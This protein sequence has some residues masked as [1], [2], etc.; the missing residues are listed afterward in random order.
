[1]PASTPRESQVGRRTDGCFFHLPR[2]TWVGCRGN[3][4]VGGV[5][6]RQL[7]W[8]PAR[9]LVFPLN[10]KLH[11]AGP[12][13]QSVAEKG[14]RG[15]RLGRLPTRSAVSGSPSLRCR[16]GLSRRVKQRAA[17]MGVASITGHSRHFCHGP[18]RV[19]P[20]APIHARRP[21]I[22]RPQQMDPARVK[23]MLPLHAVNLDVP[24]T[25]GRR[26]RLSRPPPCR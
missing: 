10:E 9:P 3:G 12:D 1:M 20:S 24:G 26:R 11:S 19:V 7:P 23:W 2:T 8:L 17:C 14:G 18:G 6:E 4:G 15:E 25:N 13:R 22:S 21:I 16:R 5:K